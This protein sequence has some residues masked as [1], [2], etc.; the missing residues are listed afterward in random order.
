M[1]TKGKWVKLAE[2]QTLPEIPSTL[3]WSDSIP[4]YL[5][6]DYRG[7]LIYGRCQQ[8]MIDA[9]FKKIDLAQP[10]SVLPACS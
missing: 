6:L 4:N 9:G 5:A 3:P 2:D 1:T 8:D 10:E 7:K